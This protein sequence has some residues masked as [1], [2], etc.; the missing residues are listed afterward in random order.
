VNAEF[1][2]L[3]ELIRMSHVAVTLGLMVGLENENNQ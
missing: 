2:S 3:I 1:Y